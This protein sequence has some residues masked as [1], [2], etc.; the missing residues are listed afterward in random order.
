MRYRYTI[1]YLLGLMLLLYVIS[2]TKAYGWLSFV[3]GGLYAF[4][5][6]VGQFEERDRKKT[7]W[8]TRSMRFM[9]PE[10][11]PPKIKSAIT[12]LNKAIKEWEDG[13]PDNQDR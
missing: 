10:T 2:K 7:E 6:L 11:A 9:V 12:K 3:L 4:A 5:Y 13:R 1:A 8:H